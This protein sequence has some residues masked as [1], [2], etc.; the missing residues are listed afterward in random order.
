V[1][2][3][4]DRC[5]ALDVHKKT[6]MACVRGP[7][8]KAGRRQELREFRTFSRDLARLRSWLEAEGVTQVAME[9][10]GVYWKPVWYVLEAASFE[11]LLAN[12]RH[13]K[14]LPGRKTDA[15]DAAWLAQLLECGLLGGSFV[16]PREIAP[17]A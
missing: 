8:A 10:T 11:L 15:A 13:V 6:V 12:A 9:A 1:D 2:V 17:A 4:V 7:D 14:N 3:I 5:A 16:P